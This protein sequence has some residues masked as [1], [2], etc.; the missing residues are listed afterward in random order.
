MRRRST[1]KRKK[2]ARGL[3][4]PKPSPLKNEKEEKKGVERQDRS[5]SFV[6]HRK[7]EEGRGGFG[8]GH[9]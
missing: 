7:L 2:D 4:P 9:S 1:E 3:L 8:L 6:C 5:Q